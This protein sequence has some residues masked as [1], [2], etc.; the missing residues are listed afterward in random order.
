M[1]TGE[2]V[3]RLICC[4]ILNT[5][6]SGSQLLGWHLASGLWWLVNWPKRTLPNF[7][8]CFDLTLL[9]RFGNEDD[10]ESDRHAIE[11][12]GCKGKCNYW[13]TGCSSWCMIISYHCTA[14]IISYRILLQTRAER[15][16]SSAC[17][18]G[19]GSLVRGSCHIVP[20]FAHHCPMFIIKHGYWL[21]S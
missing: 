1:L 19:L 17:Q 8:E 6:R 2:D 10:D 16:A 9:L 4:I 21:F 7:G 5:Q 13:Q 12:G 15:R 3:S 18:S 14:M 11:G 20:P